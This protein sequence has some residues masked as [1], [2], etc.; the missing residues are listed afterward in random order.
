MSLTI[1]SALASSALLLTRLQLAGGGATPQAQTPPPDSQE[2]VASLRSA[3]QRFEWI[4]RQHLPRVL[5]GSGGR[6]DVTV[7]RFCYWDDDGDRWQPMPEHER[8][9]RERQALVA[10]LESAAAALPGDPWIAGQRIRYLTEAAR[11][12]DALW[13]TEACRAAEWWC[14]ALRGFVLHRMGDYQAADST[15]DRALRAMNERERCTWID[16]SIV[17]EGKGRNRYED[18][19]CEARDSLNRSI[20]WLADPLYLVPGNERRTEHFARLVLDRFMDGTAIVYGSRWGRDNRELVLRY[21]WSIGWEREPSRGH[22][23]RPRVVGHHADGGMRFLPPFDYVEHPSTLTH[24]DWDI[25]PRVPRS[26]AAVRY[27]TEFRALEHQLAVFRHGDS[28]VVVVGYDLW[29]VPDN[30][31]GKRTATHFGPAPAGL[32]V[33]HD[34]FRRREV[35]QSTQT[36][37]GALSVTVDHAPA[38]VSVEVLDQLDS[39]AARSRFWLDIPARL[40][41]GFAISDLLL[42][43]EG[44]TLPSTLEDATPRAR[45]SS[46]YAPGEPIE[47]Y[48]E[49]YGTPSDTAHEVSISVVKLG[50]GVFRKAVEWMGLAGQREPERFRW[51]GAPAALHPGSGRA[52]GIRLAKQEEGRYLLRLEI[53]TEA[54]LTATKERE[55]VVKKR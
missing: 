4:R 28:A 42:L 44:G 18:G 53:R 24:D 12:H 10:G 46:R 50:K 25:D 33:H 26:R 38:L 14:D 11:Y 43:S 2:I 45:G 5:G 30:A 13:A 29:E 54:G 3:Q 47:I 21:G 8:I 55:I 27:A 51:E 49:V 6:C 22:E 36:G 19:N 32:F 31:K 1:S 48:W 15:F 17:L 37:R 52:L 35:Q 7:G 20:W 39:V 23:A 16:L 41:Q 9:V 34:P 40:P